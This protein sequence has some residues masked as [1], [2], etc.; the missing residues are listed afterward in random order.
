MLAAACSVDR[1]RIS[2]TASHTSLSCTAA[3]TTTVLLCG[4]VMLGRGI[5]Q[6]LKRPGDAT[7]HEGYMRSAVDYVDIAER[8]NGPI[9]RNVSNAYVWGDVPLMLRTATPRID[10]IVINLETA[11]TT[12]DDLW[13]G[14]AV[15]YRMHPANAAPVLSAIGVNCCAL[16][17]NHV[18]DW[19]LGGLDE[20]VRTLRAAGI[21]T[22]GAG[23][24][25]A[26]AAAPAV[27]ELG[28]QRRLLVF[29]LGSTTAGVPP[30]WGA[31][32]SKPGVLMLDGPCASRPRARALSPA[33]PSAHGAVGSVERHTP[34]PR[35]P[36]RV[37]QCSPRL[38][39]RIARARA[40]AQ[41]AG[42]PRDCLGAL[43]QQLG[44]RDPA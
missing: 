27:V 4:D 16:A 17:N 39:R 22:A 10:A 23:L 5:D 37:R 44:V 14:K 36:P 3:S 28:A 1:V 42:R 21:A 38:P 30:E 29:S 24:T 12:S 19:G 40:R 13:R 11:V 8:V 15:H 25:R 41:A 6:I 35:R 26:T 33:P 7:L 32:G 43:G 20:T 31:S 2:G 34:A 9:P 18:L